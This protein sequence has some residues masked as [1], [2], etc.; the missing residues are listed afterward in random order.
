MKSLGMPIQV[1]RRELRASHKDR[2]ILAKL[3]SVITR[4]INRTDGEERELLLEFWNEVTNALGS[5]AGCQGPHPSVTAHG[6]KHVPSEP[7]RIHE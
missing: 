1:L 6:P 4:G 2:T 5:V 7:R 3:N